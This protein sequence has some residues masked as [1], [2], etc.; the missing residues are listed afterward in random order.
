[1]RAMLMVSLMGMVACN[2]T[3]DGEVGASTFTIHNQTDE[4]LTIAFTPGPIQTPEVLTSTVSAGE[5]ADIFFSAGC[6]GCWDRPEDV[7]ATLTLTPATGETIVYDPVANDDWVEQQVG[8]YEATY[9]LTV[10]TD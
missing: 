8:E 5:T 1:M 9:T 4:A 7:L 2:G 10:P 6:F 3:V